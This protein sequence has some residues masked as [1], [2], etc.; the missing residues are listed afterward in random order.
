MQNGNSWYIVDASLLKNQAY[1][2]QI[3][4]NVVSTFDYTTTPQ[5]NVQN[6][7]PILM[8]IFPTLPLTPPQPVNNGPAVVPPI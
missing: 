6:Y 4:K 1:Q 5:S 2:Y 7:V 8:P 3:P